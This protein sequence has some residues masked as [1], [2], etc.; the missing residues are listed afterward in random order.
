[1]VKIKVLEYECRAHSYRGGKIVVHSHKKQGRNYKPNPKWEIHQQA[2]LTP[3]AQN[4][5]EYTKEIK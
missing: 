1:M 5:K 4:S 3:Y 2:S